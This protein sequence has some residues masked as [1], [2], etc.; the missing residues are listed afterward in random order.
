MTVTR[1]VSHR[2]AEQMA[3]LTFALLERCQEKQETMADALA[4][5]VAEFKVIRC[6]RGDTSITAGE[7]ARRMLLSNSRLTRILDGLVGKSLITR[8]PGTIDRR[9]MEVALTPKGR[10]AARKI[11]QTYI[12]T[13]QRIL[14]NIPSAAR[15]S[16]LSAMEELGE[17]LQKWSNR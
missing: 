6:F 14:E 10:T 15:E 16:V 17:A 13:H 11:E 1:P 8:S 12:Q 5:T 2:Q 9:V 7:L 3:D 4:L